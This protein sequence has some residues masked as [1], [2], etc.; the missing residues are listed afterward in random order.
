MGCGPCADRALYLI[1]EPIY[2]PLHEYVIGDYVV[3]SGI[4]YV[5]REND[6]EGNNPQ[7]TDAWEPTT[8]LKQLKEIRALV[9]SDTLQAL[10]YLEFEG[11]GTVYS[12]G[13]GVQ[14]N[15]KLCIANV[16]TDNTPPDDAG[17]WVS[18][19]VVYEF[20]NVFDDFQSYQK[21]LLNP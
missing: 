3:M 18:D 15:G 17:T 21:F 2:D 13:S 19:P 20:W 11:G 1:G 6:N 12:K 10:G 5:S 16:D 4:L 7:E 9:V 8:I 14:H